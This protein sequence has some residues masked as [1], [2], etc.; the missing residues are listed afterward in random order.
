M[1]GKKCR[2]VIRPWG[3]IPKKFMK[4]YQVVLDTNVLISGLR[5]RQGASFRLIELIG[6]PRWRLN[7][8]PSLI[9]EYEEVC[10]REIAKLWLHPEKLDDILDFICANA[11]RPRISYSWRPCLQDPDDDMV[12]ELAVAGNVDFI[13]THNTA[14]F[15]NAKSFK[16]GILT[17][18][19]L[20]RK[21]GEIK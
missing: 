1:I 19:E 17:P 8:S 20:L 7:I 10:R 21:I 11:S 18:R 5:S 12:L 15:K 4:V 2:S 16:L 3:Y 9:F 13:V 14:D 6:D